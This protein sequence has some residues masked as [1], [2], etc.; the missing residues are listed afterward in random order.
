[1]TFEKSEKNGVPVSGFEEP[2]KG[3]IAIQQI[4]SINFKKA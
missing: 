1:M 3:S 2:V 4:Y